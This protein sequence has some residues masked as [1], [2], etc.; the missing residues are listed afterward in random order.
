MKRQLLYGVIGALL[1][2]GAPVGALILRHLFAGA[3]PWTPWLTTEWSQFSFFYFYMTAGTITAL[4]IFGFFLGTT[5]DQLAN[6]NV[7]I[8]D[9]VAE[10]STLAITDGLTGLYNHRFLHEHLQIEI[11]RANRYNAPFSCLM[12]DIDDFKKINDSFGHP[13]GDSVLSAI[14]RI[15]R[16]CTRTTD[17]AGRYGGEEFLILMPATTQQEALMVAE[18]IRSSVESFPFTCNTQ[19]V[20]VTL[21]AG[22]AT[23]DSLAFQ[24]KNSYIQAADA[25]LYRAKHSGKNRV[26][27]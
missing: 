18:R 23:W 2:V 6:E 9:A 19:P 20:R 12:M 27:A 21:S 14:A 16:E 7:H 1:G 3:P 26:L 8:K 22:L 11:D 10:L 25:A 17:L 5:Q 24:D 4:T 15:I 13:F